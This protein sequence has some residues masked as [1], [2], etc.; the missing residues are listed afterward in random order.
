MYICKVSICGY[1][2]KKTAKFFSTVGSQKW[3]S[4]DKKSRNSSMN[5][6]HRNMKVNT[7]RKLKVIASGN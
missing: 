3:K 2:R 1:G 7:K 5:N 6:L 4:K